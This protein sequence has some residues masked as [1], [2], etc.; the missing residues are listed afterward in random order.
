MWKS[1]LRDKEKIS[2]E[3]DQPVGPLV[4]VDEAGQVF[5]SYS[6]NA[7]SGVL[8]ELAEHRHSYADVIL[9][10]QHHSRLPIEVKNLI[11]EWQ[12]C[13][14]YRKAGFP[15]YTFASYARWYGVREP[16]ATGHG[17]YRKAV[18]GLYDSHALGAGAGGTKG[19]KVSV[20]SVAAFWL[21]WPVLLV[22]GAGVALA[23]VLTTGWER[24]S[25]MVGGEIGTQG[26]DFGPVSEG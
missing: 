20:T 17:R 19:E 8:E 4:V 5:A 14:S 26:D 22:V 3:G 9:L 25:R 13:V 12:E 7:L 23:V 2:M 16:V 10:V 21:R 15:G 18:F 11:D 24:V 6:P 1:A